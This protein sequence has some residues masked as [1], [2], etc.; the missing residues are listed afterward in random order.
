MA[1]HDP[2]HA[3]QPPGRRRPRRALLAYSFHLISHGPG[4]NKAWYVRLAIQKLE[5][6]KV[7]G[8]HEAEA[9]ARL[10]AVEALPA[11]RKAAGRFY[12][13]PAD[14]PHVQRIFDA[15]IKKPINE[16]IAQLERRG[17]G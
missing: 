11:L 8:P 10:G 7:Q 14:P 4:P 5:D 13:S 1:G 3:G 15:A 6:D 9:L 17:A 16:A 2:E 12:G